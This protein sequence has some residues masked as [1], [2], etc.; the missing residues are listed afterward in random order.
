MITKS[1]FSKQPRKKAMLT[2]VQLDML[3]RRLIRT[4][5]GWLS[6]SDWIT[7][8]LLD[9]TSQPRSDTTQKKFV[10]HMQAF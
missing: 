10:K 8:L 7:Q 4:N 1:K 2:H 5:K 9:S 3:T 6:N